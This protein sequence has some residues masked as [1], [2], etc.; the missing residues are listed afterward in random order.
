[1]ALETKGLKLLKTI[2]LSSDPLSDSGSFSTPDVQGVLQFIG[3]LVAHR[4]VF[5]QKQV[6]ISDEM[7]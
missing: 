4:A 3:T 1:M 2:V 5:R 6:T 7:V